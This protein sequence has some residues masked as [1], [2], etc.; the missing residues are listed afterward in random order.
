M[1][2][3]RREF[4]LTMAGGAAGLGLAR[5]AGQVG[6]PAATPEA[7]WPPGVEE[8]INSTCLVCPSRC[9]VRARVVDGR[10]VHLDGNPLHPLSRGGLCPRGV[11][12][13]QTLYHPERLRQPL[14]RIGPRGGGSWRPLTWSSA[15]ATLA[16]RLGQLR[17]AGRPEALAVV[18]GYAAGSMEDL[19][20]QFLGAF[21]SPNYVADAYPDGTDAVA[22]AMHGIARRPAYDLERAE[23]VMSFG[24]PLFEAWWSPVQ[25][26]VAFGRHADDVQRRAR[27][28]HVDTR[29]SRT[30]ARAHEWIGVRPRSYATLA[31]GIAYV[32]LKEER[33]DGDFLRDHV[34]G[35]DDWTDAK[36]V[37]HE[38]YG[39]IVL[40]HFRTEEVSDA[41]GVPV[42]RIVRV[43]RAFAA[44]APA[45]AVYGADVTLAPDGLLAGMAV[46]SLNALVGNINRPGGVF[47]ADDPP[48]TPLAPLALDGTARRGLGRGPLVVPAPFGA[49]TADGLAEA[50]GNAD[51]GAVQVLMLYYANPLASSPSP[52]AWR[53]ALQR[54]ELVVTCSP[55]LDETAREADLI[56]PDLLPQERWQDGVAPSSYPYP[57]WMIARPVVAPPPVGMAT[58]DMLLELARRLGGTA[59]ASLPYPDVET[60][61]KARARGLF[62]TRR[63]MPFGDEF[64]TAH[65]Q[66][67]EERGWWLPSQP[68]FD[69]FWTALLER[70]G[71]TDP[72]LDTTDPGR[73]RRTASGRLELMPAAVRRHVEQPGRP[74]GLYR[75]VPQPAEHPADARYPLRLNPYRLSTLA[76]GTM[77]LAPWIAE[78]PTMLPEVHWV[79]WVEV[80]PETARA[81]DCEDGVTAWVVSPRGR[82]RARVRHFAGTPRDTVVAPYGPRHPEGALASPLQLLDGAADALT[83]LAAW[84]TTPVRLERA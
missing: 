69:G 35:F 70:G 1:R 74:D 33:V 42:E 64:E 72:F 3:K 13:V 82:Y 12:G 73:W 45:V 9:G 57:T 7:G 17:A 6:A 47:F 23:L 71:W 5:R 36:G 56:L 21:G 50:I 41:T 81:A 61:L 46:H 60:L 80:H 76:S 49:P 24:A 79:P 27:F 29:F 44:Q 18:A 51:A 10:L 62:A 39:S 40:R 16:D 83:G 28:I 34:A 68:D 58:G 75:F 20:R 59:A 32:L 66:Q 37:T 52:E 55:F 19:W 30:A 38:G 14:L 22:A 43:A 15:I 65:Q 84:C 48:L 54:V 31:L 63:G 26:F 4:V 8:R 53:R 25:A 78:R 77:H 2:L 67:M 11:A